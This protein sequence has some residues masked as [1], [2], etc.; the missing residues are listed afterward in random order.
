MTAPCRSGAEPFFLQWHITDRCN[1]QCTHCY[2]EAQRPELPLTELRRVFANFVELRRCLPQKRA[3]VQIAGGEPLLSPNLFAVLDMISAEGMQSRILTNGTLI[4]ANTAQEIKRCG[5]ATVQ[6]SVDGTRE[7]HDSL[8]GRGA[9]DKA[10]AAADVLRELGVQVTFQAVLSRANAGQIGEIFAIALGHADRVGFCRLVPCGSGGGLAGE[11][12]RPRELRKAFRRIAALKRACPAIDVPLR[13]PLWHSLAKCVH[14][15]RDI[16][17][18]SAGWGGICVES[19]GVVYPCRRMPVAIGNAVTDR[20]VDL[21]H[22]PLMMSLRDRNLLKGKCGQCALRWR[23]GGC[24][25]MPYA[26]TGDPLGADPQCFYRPTPFEKL[27]R[28]TAASFADALDPDS[29]GGG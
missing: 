6:I 20:L 29:G 8:R 25:A 26:L 19:D 12:L 18:C 1:L 4:D 15:S 5:C 3:R 27:L 21:W 14:V 7:A 17:G 13:D 9:F 10:I 28:R 22:A 11:M 16:G 2:R 23:C 24:R